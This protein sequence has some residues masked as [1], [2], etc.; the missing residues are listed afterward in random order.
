MEAGQY[1]VPQH[2][3]FKH[4]VFNVY[5]YGYCFSLQL[6]SIMSLKQDEV[7]CSV[8]LSFNKWRFIIVLNG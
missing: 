4:C 6:E 7:R 1:I 8:L 2:I 5:F 3:T